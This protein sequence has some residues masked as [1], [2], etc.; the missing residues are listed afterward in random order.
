MAEYIDN[1]LESNADGNDYG[2]LYPYAVDFG[3]LPEEMCFYD[4][5]KEKFIVKKYGRQI[6]ILESGFNAHA[7]HV[8]S[9]REYSG[10]LKDKANQEFFAYSWEEMVRKTYW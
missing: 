10:Y 6:S 7:T 5:D 1:Y 8:K 3:E 9:I 4:N 2:T